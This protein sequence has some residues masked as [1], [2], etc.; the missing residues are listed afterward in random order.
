MEGGTQN[1]QPDSPRLRKLEAQDQL[2]A[3]GG[4]DSLRKREGESIRSIPFR[5]DLKT[6]KSAVSGGG[7]SFRLGHQKS[8]E[9]LEKKEEGGERKGG[10]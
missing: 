6:L 10:D 4:G 2:K 9:L 8:I 7:R 1:E 3:R 5:R